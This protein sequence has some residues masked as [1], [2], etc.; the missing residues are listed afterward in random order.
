LDLFAR[1]LGKTD[2]FRRHDLFASPEFRF[3]FAD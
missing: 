3:G 2:Y 1:L